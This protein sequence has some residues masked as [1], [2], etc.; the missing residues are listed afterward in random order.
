MFVDPR[1]RSGIDALRAL[2]IQPVHGDL[3]E[4]RNLLVDRTNGAGVPLLTLN[5][6]VAAWTEP[7]D[8]SL[9]DSAQ[10]VLRKQSLRMQ[11]WSLIEIMLADTRTQEPDRQALSGLELLLTLSGSTVSPAEGRK[12]DP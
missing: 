11:V 5:H 7:G 4:F 1:F 2:G 10:A 6:V 9:T 3:N 12:A 8:G